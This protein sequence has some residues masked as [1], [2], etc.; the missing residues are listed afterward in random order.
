MS[1][2]YVEGR[3]PRFHLGKPFSIAD[4]VCKS[5]T[6][7]SVTSARPCS[8]DDLTIPSRCGKGTLRRV[9]EVFDCWF[10]SGSMPYA[11]AHYPFENLKQF[12]DTFPADFIAEGI[13]QTRGW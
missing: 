1:G 7:L 5:H 3:K 10:E 4:T 12:E 9:S 11:Q 8:I 2:V 13:D 6:D